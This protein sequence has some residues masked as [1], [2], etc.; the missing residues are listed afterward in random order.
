[1]IQTSPRPS[2]AGLSALLVIGFT[3]L[4]TGPSAFGCG[5]SMAAPQTGATP[6]SVSTSSS[7]SSEGQATAADCPPAAENPQRAHA[8][9][10][11][12]FWMPL[13]ERV[14]QALAQ[15]Y[16]VFYG[17]KF[18]DSVEATG[19][20]FKHQIVDDAGRDYKAVHYDHG[21]GVAAAD[22]DGD[23]RLDLYFTSQMGPNELWR[24]KGGGKFENWTERAGVA[25][26]DRISVA[27]SF[28]DIDN[29]GDPDLFVTTVRHGNLLFRNDGGGKFTDI[30]KAAGI[31]HVGH[32]SGAVFFD[33]NHDGLLD[34]FVTNVGK[35]TGETQ[36]RGGYWIGYADAFSGHVFPDRTEN[37]ILYRNVGG[38]RFEDVSAEMGLVDGS[39]S[40][41][42]GLIDANDDGWMDLYLL[43]MQGHDELWINE[44]GNRFVKQSRKYFPATPWGAM[45]IQIFDFNNDG[46]QDIFVTD[47]HTDMIEVLPPQKEKSKMTKNRPVEAL[48]TDGNHVLGNALFRNDGGGKFTEVSESMGAENFWPWGLSSGDL[49]AD[50]WDDVYITSSMNYPWRYGVSSLLL[51]EKGKRF[52]DSEFLVGVEPRKGGATAKPWFVLNCSGADSEHSDCKGKTGCITVMGALG[53]RSSVVFDLEGDGDL[54]IVTNE[55]NA[56]PM[57]LV[58]NL[59][60]KQP[61]NFIEVDL[62]GTTTNRQGLGATVK[63]T[64]GDQTYVKVND[65]ESGY[66]SHSDIPLYFGLGDAK[67]VDR[68]EVLWPSGMSQT[69]DGPKINARAVVKEP[70]VNE[71]AAKKAVADQE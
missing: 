57:V 19:I 71:P 38:K 42:A 17:F 26:A 46:R 66:L 34:L 5:H 48:A 25:V 10:L 52:V 3:L 31:D 59:S 32:S 22:V 8:D 69:V 4:V 43:N 6:S 54:D 45:G 58:S 70:V 23:G 47:M 35:Y 63:V 37:S 29:D 2:A 28:G 68:I 11:D 67:K 56:E 55:F 41:D 53:T 49:N 14:Q 12:P 64:A 44:K 40:G 27:G 7:A 51:N 50:G 9:V 21:N 36:G 13:R 15:K 62:E 33:F 30:S 24:N 61:V 18:E 60:E 16:D 39:W 20:T 1:M 65:G